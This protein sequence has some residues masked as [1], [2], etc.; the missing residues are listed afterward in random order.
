[1]PENDPWGDLSMKMEQ[2][3]DPSAI[4]NI[5]ASDIIVNRLI[6]PGLDLRGG[7]ATMGSEVLYRH[8]V[9]AR[10]PYLSQVRFF[11]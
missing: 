11:V 4:I 8:R 5:V 3:L 2:R 7:V 9:L 10:C 1:M 6:I